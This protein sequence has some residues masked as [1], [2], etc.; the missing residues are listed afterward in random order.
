MTKVRLAERSGPW[1]EE[2]LCFLKSGAVFSLTIKAKSSEFPRYEPMFQR[3]KGSF[4]F[5]CGSVEHKR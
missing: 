1:I 2:T 3:V 4:S 5:N